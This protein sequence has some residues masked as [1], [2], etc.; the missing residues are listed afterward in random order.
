M[1]FLSF[2]KKKIFLCPSWVCYTVATAVYILNT[3]P[4]KS[5]KNRVPQEAWTGLKHSVVHLKFFGCVSYTHV[6][7]ELR[8]KLDNKG[9]KLY[10]LGILKTQ[11]DTSCM[12]LS[13]ENL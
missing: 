3:C 13:Q 5:T 4:K 6:P 10:L 2:K 12:T 1:E 11:K 9:Q 7:D 8:K